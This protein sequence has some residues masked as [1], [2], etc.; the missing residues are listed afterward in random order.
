MKWR[1]LEESAPNPDLRPLHEILAERKQLIAKYIPPETK[2]IHA[3]V[4]AELQEKRLAENILP[5]GAQAPAFELKDHNGK[6][7]SPANLLSN[8]RLV[9]C[10]FRGRWCPFC[11]SQLEAMNLIVSQIEQAAASLV[12]ISPQTAQHSWPKRARVTSRP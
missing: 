12:A 3:R 7:V 8:G 2:A 1:S 11:V 10:F 4:L 9:L 6:P 5:V